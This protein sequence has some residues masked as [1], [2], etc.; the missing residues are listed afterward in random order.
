MPQTSFESL[1]SIL[2]QILIRALPEF[3]SDEWIKCL[4]AANI[5]I[6]MDGKGKWLANVVI[7]GFWR[8]I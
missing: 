8:I 1:R 2:D 5:T 4:N 7:E 6:S 3:T